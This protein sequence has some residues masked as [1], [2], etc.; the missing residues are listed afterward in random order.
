LKPFHIINGT[1][2]CDLSHLL[3]TPRD[4][5]QISP[6]VLVEDQPP[7]FKSNILRREGEKKC[8]TGLKST[9]Y[10]NRAEEKGGLKV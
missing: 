10:T 4:R 9:A 2:T 8:K 5:R 1:S 7:W 6:E 3:T